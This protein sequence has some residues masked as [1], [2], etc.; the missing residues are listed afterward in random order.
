MTEG[1]YLFD[2]AEDFL[3]VM[4]DLQAKYNENRIKQQEE[5]NKLGVDW[6]MYDN[7]TLKLFPDEVIL[8]LI[9][10]INQDPKGYEELLSSALKVE[11]VIFNFLSE[12]NSILSDEI[13]TDILGDLYYAKMWI[14][15]IKH[16]RHLLKIEPSEIDSIKSKAESIIETHNSICEVQA[17]RLR[18]LTTE[19]LLL[20]FYN[21]KN[22]YQWSN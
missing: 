14:E 5:P 18:N 11:D 15:L 13:F 2:N 10:D 7:F 19:E 8:K 4:E 20:K 12:S 21:V 17:E 1:V 22:A 9:Y 3:K 6:L 16:K